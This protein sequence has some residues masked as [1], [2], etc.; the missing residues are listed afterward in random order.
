LEDFFQA[1]RAAPVVDEA[2]RTAARARLAATV[3]HAPLGHVAAGS[4][5][6]GAGKVLAVI[7]LTVGV[8]AGTVAVLKSSTASKPSHATVQPLPIVGEATQDERPQPMVV[9]TQDAAEEPRPPREQAV[10]TSTANPPAS[11]R[12]ATSSESSTKTTDQGSHAQR[13]RDAWNAI[14]G[15]E[16]RRALSLVTDDERVSPE[17]V[18]KEE[19][20]AIRVLALAALTRVDEARVAAAAFVEHY[21]A[22]VHRALVERAVARTHAER[23]AQGGEQ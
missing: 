1:E 10:P 5:L 14:R 20:E 12:V 16:P 8:G 19:R 17:G 7:A 9:T 15:D 13:I 3:G 21:P 4:A 18:L 22:S 6:G 11:R 2:A 23:A